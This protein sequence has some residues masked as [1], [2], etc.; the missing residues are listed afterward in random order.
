VATIGRL[1]TAMVTPFKDNGTV[2]YEAAQKLAIALL[3]SGSAG[4]V[5]A[6]TTGEA[7]SLSKAEKLQLFREVK[8]AV[9]ER[10][11]VIAGTG[12]DGVVR[13]QRQSSDDAHAHPRTKSMTSDAD[14]RIRPSGLPSPMNRPGQ[15]T[16]GL[17][18]TA[19]AMKTG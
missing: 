8:A 9:G 5:V 4:L 10:G 16:F 1:L 19:L 3:D 18:T 12:S 2:D 6:G 14:R 17:S 7:P 15:V 13:A 11:C